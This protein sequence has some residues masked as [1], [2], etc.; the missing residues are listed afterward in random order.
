MRRAD[1][2]ARIEAH[3]LGDTPAEMRPAF[4]RLTRGVDIPLPHGIKVTNMPDVG[5]RVTGPRPGPE[6][7][8]FHGGGYVFGAPDTHLRAAA[9]LAARSGARVTLPRYPLAP[10][11]TWPAQR[12]AALA[13]IPDGPVP[14]LA[15]DSAGGH[16][17]LVTAL[18]LARQGRPPPALL[19]F[20]PNTDRSGLSDTR[21]A[22]E[23]S[24]PMV[25]DASDRRLARMCFMGMPGDHPEVSPV[26]DD[27][28]LLPPTLIEV[29]AEEVL[30]GDARVLA[31]RARDRGA[32]V[33][34]HEVPGMIH[35]GQVWAPGW[36][37]ANASLGRAMGFA[38]AFGGE[39]RRAS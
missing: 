28:S 17:A 34:L 32:F 20:S 23:D 33:K 21:R 36:Q 22:N 25:D 1:I 27:L 9:R 19:L 3:P 39:R 24:D 8:W 2:L 12:H 29:G 4:D 13:A 5:L 16:L 6:V 7:I 26:L 14:I 37:R 30:L 31:R 10:E 15:G 11:A 38:L 18:A 35:M